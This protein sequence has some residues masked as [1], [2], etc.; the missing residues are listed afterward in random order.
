M[1]DDVIDDQT[2][3]IDLVQDAGWDVSRIE[4]Q[5]IDRFLDDGDGTEVQIEL[6]VTREYGP[7][8]D[9]FENPFRVK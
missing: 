5:E 2:D 6:A 1:D 3:L 9:E 7:E 4:I 8:D